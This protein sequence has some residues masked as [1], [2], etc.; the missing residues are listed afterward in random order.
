MFL[1]EPLRQTPVV[2]ECDVCIIGGSCTG[3]FAAVRAAQLGAS[4]ALVENNGMFGGVAT[5][6]MVS[7]WHSL[8]E[9]SGERA[10]ISG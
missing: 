6:G 2:H 1:E 9:T 10:I 4:V 7:I 8:R 5:A 3:V